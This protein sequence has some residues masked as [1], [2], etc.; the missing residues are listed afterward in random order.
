MFLMEPVTI[1][2]KRF[3]LLLGHNKTF[4]DVTLG[5]GKLLQTSFGVS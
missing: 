3:G 4:K 5:S 2:M 1:N